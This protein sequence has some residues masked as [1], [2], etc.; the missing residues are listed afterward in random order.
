MTDGP[1][2]KSPEEIEIMRVAG[3][4]VREALERIEDLLRPGISTLELDKAVEELFR[5]RGGTPAFLGYPSAVA[6]VAPFP[7]CICASINEEVVHGIP[8]AERRLREGDIISIDVGVEK[9]GFFGDAART[10]CVGEPS[11]RVRKLLDAGRAALDAAC[12]ALRPGVPLQRV[13]RA[14]QET[15]E[16]HRFEVV[17][18]FV[19]HGIGRRMHEPPQVPNFVSRGSREG[20]IILEEGAV[21]AIEPMLNAGTGDVRILDDGWTVVTADGQLSAHFENTVALGPNGADVLT[22]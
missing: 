2:R 19:G 11:R 4:I 13:S 15:A 7:G 10:F 5:E 8:S 12:K 1:I 18:K 9:D 16:A 14:V 20:T 21:L 6:G 22:A 17:R 3:G